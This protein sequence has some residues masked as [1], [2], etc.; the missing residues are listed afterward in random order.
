MSLLPETIR[1]SKHN[2]REAHKNLSS[3]VLE[4]P[5]WLIILCENDNA[6]TLYK[7]KVHS[8]NKNVVEIATNVNC[9]RAAFSDGLVYG[10]GN[11]FVYFSVLEKK[12]LLNIGFKALSSKKKVTDA[13]AR[14]ELP[15]KRT[16]A[17]CQRKLLKH[18]ENISKQYKRVN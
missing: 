2:Q 9:Q 14:L 8:L 5:G 6:S 13:L 1:F 3:I 16:V 4:Q 11:S 17:E 18:Q 12:N 15:V 7:A 10:F